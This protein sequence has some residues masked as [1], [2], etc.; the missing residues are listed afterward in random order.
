MS[1]SF[2]LPRLEGAK[3]VARKNN[4]E[5]ELAVF[6]GKEARLNLA[7][8]EVLAKDS[9]QTIKELRT[10]VIKQKSLEETYYASLTKRL[11]SLQETGYVKKI[12][13]VK[14]GSNLQF[15]ELR[16]K[17]YLASFLKTYSIQNIVDKSTDQQAAS[18][19]LVLL[20][21]ILEEKD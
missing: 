13:P 5:N 7:I 17:A 3:T 16:I 18:V 10:Q 14:P 11:R 21:V 15:F 19:L 4:K 9:P 12:Q 20:N 8:F 2:F 6:M 1:Q